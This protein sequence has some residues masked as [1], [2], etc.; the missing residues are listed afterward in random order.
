[1]TLNLNFSF[2]EGGFIS[3]KLPRLNIELY[4]AFLH[5]LINGLRFTFPRFFEVKIGVGLVL[6]LTLP[7]LGSASLG[8]DLSLRDD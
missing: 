3:F 6:F 2:L 8:L 7:T 1:M 4:H 5:Y